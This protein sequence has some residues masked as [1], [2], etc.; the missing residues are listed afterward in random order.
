ML[1]KPMSAAMVV[2][3][4]LV[5]PSIDV[6]LIRF[7]RRE[8]VE[9]I[10][11]SKKLLLSKSGLATLFVDNRNGALHP[12]SPKVLQHHCVIIVTNLTVY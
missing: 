9:L 1:R 11:V 8:H 4:I 5:A 10:S 12:S 6:S 7:D 3:F 2:M